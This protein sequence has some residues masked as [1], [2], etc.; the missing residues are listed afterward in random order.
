M[1]KRIDTLISDIFGFL[2]ADEKKVSREE[3]ETFGKSLAE[4]LYDRFTRKQKFSLRVSNLGTPCRR[5]L[6]YSA[7][8]PLAA[9]PLSGPN[10][11][12]F[13]F[14]DVIEELVLLLARLTGHTVSDEQA[15]VDI[16]GVRGH[17]DAVVDGRL[18]DVKSASTPSFNKFKAGLVPENDGFGYLGQLG[19][20]AH[21]RSVDVASFLVVDKTLGNLTLDTHVF[22]DKDHAQEIS[23]VREVL[24]SA[25]PPDRHYQDKEFG[26]SGNRS[27]GFECNYCAFK[28]EC[29][30]G[31]RR[32]AYARG[33]VDL[34]VVVDEPA[35]PEIT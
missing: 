29:W 28:R 5:K 31:L 14:G 21:G 13:I 17:I 6:W 9:E 18:V 12:K 24:A 33:P 3:V 22:Q 20:Y 23:E 1:P 30:P 15:E 16:D 4:K 34:S 35:V 32:F 2:T 7:N 25:G 19:S 10:H 26:K 8:R 27:L 11:L